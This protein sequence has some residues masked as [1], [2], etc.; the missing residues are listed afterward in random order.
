ML[1]HDKTS[2]EWTREAVNCETH[3]HT[4]HIT[5]V[6][7]SLDNEHKL[8]REH[9]VLVHHMITVLLAA[10]RPALWTDVW[11]A[12]VPVCGM[13][14]NWQRCF[15]H[16]A[17]HEQDAYWSLLHHASSPLDRWLADLCHLTNNL[18]FFMLLFFC[19]LQHK[20]EM[21]THEMK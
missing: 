6:Y 15:H 1:H 14:S 21:M 11:P 9:V 10:S 7:I 19:K 20:H 12:T 8:T 5:T 16:S 4:H 18:F 3:T 17:R 2:F 13:R